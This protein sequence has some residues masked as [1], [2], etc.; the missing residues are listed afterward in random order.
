MQGQ[1]NIHEQRERDEKKNAAQISAQII[2]VNN[3][4]EQGNNRGDMKQVSSLCDASSLDFN[5]YVKVVAGNGVGICYVVHL[6]MYT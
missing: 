5:D 3:T 4:C 1:K 2:C 6:M